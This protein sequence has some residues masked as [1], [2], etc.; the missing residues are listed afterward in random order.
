MNSNIRTLFTKELTNTAHVRAHT[1]LKLLFIGVHLLEDRKYTYLVTWLNGI[2][3]R[4]IN[5]GANKR[6][7]VIGI[8]I[9]FIM[10]RQIRND[11]IRVGHITILLNNILNFTV[12]AH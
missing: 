9:F 12:E 6:F 1:H 10:A 2:R 3:V 4:N 5:V 7:D 11:D 8:V